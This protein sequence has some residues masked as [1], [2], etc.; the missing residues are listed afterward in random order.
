MY[1][2]FA[3]LH[4]TQDTVNKLLKRSLEDAK[5]LLNIQKH[6]IATEKI[7]TIP[8]A[9]VIY[10]FWREKNLPKIHETLQRNNIYSVGRY[11]EWKYSS[12]QEALLDGKKIADK[13]VIMPALHTYYIPDMMDITSPQQE[14]TE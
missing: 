5:K 12:M 4:E 14:V 2:E 8:H 11:G 3:Y 13:L 7:I 9:Y 6:E 10:D 1:G